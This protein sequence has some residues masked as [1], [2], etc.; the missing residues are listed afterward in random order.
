ML[1]GMRDLAVVEHNLLLVRLFSLLITLSDQ[2]QHCVDIFCFLLAIHASFVFCF[3]Y[4]IGND[5]NEDANLTSKKLKKFCSF[6]YVITMK[7]LRCVAGVLS[8]K[9]V[10]FSKWVLE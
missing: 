4:I 1:I 6:E 9:K 3:R 10:A 5:F 2:N 8:P 7:I